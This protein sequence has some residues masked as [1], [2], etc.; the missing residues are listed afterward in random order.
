MD[1]L[2]DPHADI[3]AFCRKWRITELSVFGSAARGE[4][5]P[6]SDLDALVSFEP[7]ADWDLLDLL[8]VQD[9]LERIVGRRVDMVE[10]CAL[11]SS[12]NWI[13]RNEILGSA[14]PVYARS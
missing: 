7:D 11:E 10:R 6:D 14:V 13:V 5:R 1:L 4:L 8:H 2:G 3:E 9:D 12:E